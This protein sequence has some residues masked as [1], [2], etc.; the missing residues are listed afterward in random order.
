MMESK[1]IGMLA[2]TS[3]HAGT[4]QSSGFV[5]LPVARESATDYPVIMGTS[6][7]GALRQLAG[8][9]DDFDEDRV[10]NIFGKR[11][12]AGRLVVSDGR[13]VLLPVR[14]LDGHYRWLTCPHLLERLARDRRRTGEGSS[15]FEVPGLD[16]G[17]TAGA[18]QGETLFLEE[19]QFT[20]THP[21]PEGVVDLLEPLVAHDAT[22]NRIEQQ[23]AVL[24]DD[25]FSWF[26]QY[27]LSVNAR[28]VLEEKTKTSKNL[29]YEESLPADSLFYTVLGD[30][31]GSSP[32][33]LSAARELV[34]GEDAYLQVGGNETVGQGWFALEWLDQ[35]GQ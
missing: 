14:S 33:G 4:G 1:I 11:D 5:D 29:W 3:V 25:D 15:S 31:S 26:A 22:R 35:G 2:E 18:E 6:L 23:T 27:G 20:V 30:R 13:L 17:E 28:N 8:E 19:R 16:D 10:D 9:T 24:H 32:Q 12:D 7:K 21:L 34:G